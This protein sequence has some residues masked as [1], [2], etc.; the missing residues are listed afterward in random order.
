[1]LSSL[2]AVFS[3]ITAAVAIWLGVQN[4]RRAWAAA[5]AQMYL[6][7]RSA[8]LDILAELGDVSDPDYVPDQREKTAR[9]AYWHHAYDEWR[10]SRDAPQEFG[11]LWRNHFKQATLAGYA[12]PGLRDTFEYLSGRSE[13]GFGAYAQDFISEF[14]ESRP[15]E[16]A[17][18][19][20]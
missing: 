19:D 8:F 11:D 20:S 12:H 10:V 16:L 13:Q 9:I 5:K 18:S 14:N 7:L 4:N 1:V 3:A 6:S 15:A 17:P 2:A